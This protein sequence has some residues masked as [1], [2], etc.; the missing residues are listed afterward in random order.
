MVICAKRGGY[1]QVVSE[2]CREAYVQRRTVRVYRS[3]EL[4]GA[5]RGFFFSTS[6]VHIC[7]FRGRG[8]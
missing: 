8:D 2:G 7:S 5:T 6:N 3:H 1:V 4:E